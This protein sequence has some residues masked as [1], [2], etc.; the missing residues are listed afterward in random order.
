[1]KN[2]K[3]VFAIVLAMAMVMAMSLTA[4][5]EDTA[6]AYETA[7]VTVSG[8]TSGDTLNL[9]KVFTATVGSDNTITYTAES[10]VPEAYD[11]VDEIAAADAATAANALAAA[12]KAN[13]AAVAYSATANGNLPVAAGYYVANA[14]GTN[15]EVVYQNMLINAVMKSNSSTNSYDAPVVPAS[16]KS[17]GVTVDKDVTGAADDSDTTDAY[18]VGDYVPF[19]V[20]TAIP[21]YPSNSTYATFTITDA[22]TNLSIVN[23]SDHEVTVTVGGTAVSAAADTYSLDVTGGSMTIA[24]VKDYILA[25]TGAPVVVTYSAKVED[26]A[27]VSAAGA[28]ANDAKVTFNP[29]PYVDT[30]N[31]VEDI[32]TVKTYGY[33]FQKVGKDNAALEG[34]TFTLYSDEACETPVTKADGTTAMTSTSAKVGDAAYVYFSGL[35]ADTT[36]YVKET[37]V[38]AGYVGCENFSFTLSSTTAAAD[39]PATADITETNYLVN[40]T[41]VVNTPGAEL[42]ETGGIGTTIFYIVG[43]ILVVGAGLVLITRRRMSI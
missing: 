29:N 25:N 34:A 17:T 37:T 30:T 13:S 14:E 18:K 3:K 38:P 26:A 35:K 32:V 8:L 1:M 16:V 10:W 7:T 41:A 33:V 5:A 19:T 15:A 23:D 42:P 2:L 6:P 21:N 36:Y 9:Y 43:A 24:F 12:A 4:F 28:A 27:A 22:P 31:D 11:T 40:Q 20:T 39:N